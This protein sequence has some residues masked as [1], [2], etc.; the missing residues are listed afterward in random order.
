[1]NLITPSKQRAS[2]GPNSFSPRDIVSHHEQ[3]EKANVYQQQSDM[4]SSLSIASTFHSKQ[5]KKISAGHGI[6]QILALMSDFN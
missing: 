6:A 5:Q 3:V 2:L 4:S 1:V